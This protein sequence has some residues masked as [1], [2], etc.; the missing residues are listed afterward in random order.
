MMVSVVI[1]CYN[2]EK[3]IEHVV[4]EIQ[5]TLLKN[6]NVIPEFVLVNDCSKDKTGEVIRGLA[7]KQKNVTAI[8]LSHNSGQHNAIMTGFR[9]VQGDAVLVAEDDGQSPIEVVREMIQ[10][11]NEGFDAVCVK[12]EGRERKSLL[13]RLG[14]LADGKITRWLID[15]PDNVD[16]SVNF[17]AKRFVVDEMTRYEGPYSYIS[18]LLFRTTQN[19]G[20][21][22]AVQHNRLQGSSGYNFG[23]LLKLWLNGFTA[24]SVKPLRISAVLG[25]G[26][27]GIGFLWAVILIIR[28]LVWNDVQMGWTSLAVILLIMGGLI[29]CALGLIGEYL[30]RIY[31]CINNS[32]QAVVSEIT[33]GAECQSTEKDDSREDR[34]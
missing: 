18:G 23:K 2:S 32:P 16:F 17:I 12:Y 25:A 29:L 6:E 28:R 21:V 34:V 24:F 14:T 1:P 31:M 4:H 11:L 30:G 7:K 9:F 26:F 8:S 22:S 15:I 20:N 27:A 19:V 3:T 5:E 13:R 10:K 33:R